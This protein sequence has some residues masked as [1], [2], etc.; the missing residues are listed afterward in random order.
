MPITRDRLVARKDELTTQL[1]PLKQ[2]YNAVVGA[3]ADVEYWI[4]E[5]ATPVVEKEQ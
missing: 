3:V 1:E 2:Q 5:D 4:T